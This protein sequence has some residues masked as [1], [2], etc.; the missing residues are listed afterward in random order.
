VHAGLG[1]QLYV[2]EH[3][4][5]R[6]QFDLHYVPNFTNQFGSTMAPSAMIWLGYSMG[7]R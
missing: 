4:F 5:I 3:V 1:V 2:T 6:P 7:D